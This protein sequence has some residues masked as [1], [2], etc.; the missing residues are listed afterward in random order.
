MQA[1][2]SLHCVADI[3]TKHDSLHYEM[4]LFSDPHVILN[5]YDF[6]GPQHVF[7]LLYLDRILF[8]LLF[9]LLIENE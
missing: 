2:K 7:V 5:V 4:L 9:Y 6:T 8:T 3:D 1:F